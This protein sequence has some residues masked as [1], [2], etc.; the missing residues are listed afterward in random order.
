MS[1]HRHEDPV[2]T[3]PILISAGLLVALTIVGAGWSSYMKGDTLDLPVSTVVTSRDLVFSDRAD[4]AVVVTENGQEVLVIEAGSGGFVR[5]TLRALARHRQLGNVGEEEPFRLVH[6]AD[7]RLS[8]IDPSTNGRVEINAFG[9]DQLDAFAQILDAPNVVGTVEGRAEGRAEGRSD[10]G[11][12]PV[13]STLQVNAVQAP[14][15]AQDARP[16]SR[17]ADRAGD[18]QQQENEA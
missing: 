16:D 3:R 11:A 8:L 10:S 5:G 7:G 6:W 13:E 12:D 17:Q 14:A 2:I 9:Q 4:G 1:G 18:G 15:D